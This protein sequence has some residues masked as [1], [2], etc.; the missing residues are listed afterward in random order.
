MTG[1]VLAFLRE[2]LKGR[3]TSDMRIDRNG[4]ERF[5]RLTL[6]HQFAHESALL[7]QRLRDSVIAELQKDFYR[8]AIFGGH[9]VDR[10][11]ESY[12]LAFEMARLLGE[13]SIDALY[14]GGPGVMEAVPSGIGESGGSSIAISVSMG[15]VDQTNT[16]MHHLEFTSA[17]YGERLEWFYGLAADC[18]CLDG[19]FGTNLEG[20]Y[21]L[22]IS[23]KAELAHR[24]DRNLTESGRPR[25]D[26]LYTANPWVS[27]GHVPKV[28]YV[29]EMWK[30]QQIQLEAFIAAGTIRPEDAELAIFVKSPAEALDVLQLRRA[31]WRER[32]VASGRVPRN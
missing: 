1:C 26:L 27:L 17:N 31:S 4:V 7:T 15:F 9:L 3:L 14:G 25:R 13:E 23:Q 2:A 11:S 24:L 5:R 29:G 10:E 18:V 32:L 30:P 20:N 8:V 19:G 22:Q 16:E 6:G 21:F 28:V 12:S